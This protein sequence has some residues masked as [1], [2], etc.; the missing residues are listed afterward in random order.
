MARTSRREWARRIAAWR[1]SGLSG[2]EFAT[3]IQV[4]EGTLRH[5]KWLLAHEQRRAASSRAVQ[6]S[7]VEVAPVA[8][9]NGEGDRFELVLG[10]DR[11]V[12]VPRGFDEGELRRLIAILEAE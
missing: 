6:P 10:R 5:W 4:K 9:R 2:A 8:I 11:R 3:R 7:F 1:K 12:L